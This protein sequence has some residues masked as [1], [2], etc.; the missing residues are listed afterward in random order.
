MSDDY[1][2]DGQPIQAGLQHHSVVLTG[3]APS[4]SMFGLHEMLVVDRKYVKDKGNR[5][6]SQVEYTCRD[7]HTGDLI[8][9]C[10]RL[11]VMSGLTN[12]DDDVLHPSMQMRP[13]VAPAKSGIKQAPAQDTDGDRVLVGFIGGS[14]SRAAIIGVFRHSLATYGA[15]AE[16][17]ERRLTMHQGTTI[18]IQQDGQYVITHKT[19]SVITLLTSGD[20]QVK[21]ASG[22]DVF[23][24]DQGASEN[25]VLGQKFKQFASDLIDALLVA[26]YPTGVGPSGP[27]LPPSS[28]TLNTLKAQLDTLLSDMAYTQKEQ[29]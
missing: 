20:V 3:N 16:N 29:S 15:T 7:L 12:G 24:G 22:K 5:S 17:G 14:R 11:D 23:I 9:G 19:G 13:G 6:R 28:V 26:I 2:N 27:M 1:S 21:P 25:L 4:F 18:E 10:R 8:V